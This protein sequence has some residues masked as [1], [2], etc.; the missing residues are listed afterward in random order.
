MAIHKKLFNDI[1]V[2]SISD[3][4][5]NAQFLNSFG[6][7]R[8]LQT[9]SIVVPTDKQGALES[10]LIDALCEN[11]YNKVI[12]EKCTE[13]VD[14][15]KPDAD[16]YIS[17]D[18]LT[19]KTYLSVVFAVM[20][21]EKVFDFIQELLHEVPWEKSKTLKECFGELQVLTQP[22]HHLDADNTSHPNTSQLD[23]KS[24]IC[25]TFL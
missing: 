10:V 22:I 4:W 23:T 11:E 9:L 13:F 25:Y 2:N 17:T 6:E 16:K 19:L 1:G 14:T 15:I 3:R 12:V 24:G 20:F 21:P 8:E 5:T 7:V 18:R